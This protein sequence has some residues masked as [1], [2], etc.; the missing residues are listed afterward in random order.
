MWCMTMFLEIFFAIHSLN[1]LKYILNIKYKV[2]IK[3]VKENEL[4]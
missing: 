2:N 4:F 3:H 1:I